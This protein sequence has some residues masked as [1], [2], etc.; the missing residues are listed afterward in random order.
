M[1]IEDEP[2]TGAGVRL[3]LEEVVQKGPSR[4]ELLALGQ[5]YAFLGVLRTNDKAGALAFW[6]DKV[7]EETREQ[8]GEEKFGYIERLF[9][10]AVQNNEC[11]IALPY[12]GF[13]MNSLE[14]TQQHT[15]QAVAVLTQCG[16]TESLTLQ[17]FRGGVV[18]GKTVWNILH[19]G[20]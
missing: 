10:H 11:D 17:R 9:E 5:W 13:M 16:L 1:S 12:L 19:V 6:L 18:T 3:V 2:I 7:R 8:Y 15:I 20:K 14:F 4:S